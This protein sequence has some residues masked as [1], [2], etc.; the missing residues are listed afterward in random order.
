VLGDVVSIVSG[1]APVHAPRERIEVVRDV[2]SAFYLHLEV[3]DR[4]GVLA[5]IIGSGSPGIDMDENALR[6]TSM[7]SLSIRGQYLR[8]SAPRPDRK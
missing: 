2:N 5:A 4:P 7:F 1:E 3:A 6:T 8:P